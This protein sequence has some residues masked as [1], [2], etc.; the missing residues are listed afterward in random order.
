MYSEFNT[1]QQ[2]SFCFGTMGSE[3]SWEHW[4]AGSIP[5]LAQ[6]VRDAALLQLWLKSR[7]QLGSDPWP[8]HVL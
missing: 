3:A 7:L 8:D 2:G 4:D 6:W 5:C 1:I